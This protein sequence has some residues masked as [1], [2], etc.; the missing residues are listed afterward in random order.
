MS[1]RKSLSAGATLLVA[2][3]AATGASAQL[4]DWSGQ[5]ENVGATP[6]PDGGF[7]ESLDEVLKELQWAPP[8]KPE[9]RAVVEDDVAPE[10]EAPP[11]PLV[12]HLPGVGEV[13]DEGAGLVLRHQ[14][15]QRQLEDLARG[16]VGGDPRVELDRR[17]LERHDQGVVPRQGQRRRR[18]A[19]Q[20]LPRP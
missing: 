18:T 3:V 1:A 2:C 14:A 9:A 5:W 7:Y 8:L 12:E 13:G 15:V 20:R 4:P 19:R 11:P 6:S 10:V 16:L 17:A